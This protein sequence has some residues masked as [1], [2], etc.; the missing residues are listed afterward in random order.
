MKILI[1]EDEHDL[2][3]ALCKHLKKN[4]YG[5]DSCFNGKEALEFLSISAY[6]AIILDVQ[7]PVMNGYEFL[8]ALRSSQDTTPVL[9]LTARDS[10][11]DRVFG[12]DMGADD[13]LVK[14]FEF[15]E[16]LARIRVM[17]R[18]TYG[19]VV[20]EILIDDLMIDLSKKKVTRAAQEILLT[21]KEYEILAYLAVNQ[22]HILSRQQIQDHVWDFDYE[23]S[24]NLIDVLIKNIRKKI[25][26]KN[27]SP[28]IY[29]KR[30]LGYVIKKS[31]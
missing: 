10:L 28:L 31:D 17:T 13:Y 7:M 18:R 16:L 14:P 3:N 12:L 27:S 2:N 24:S 4:G 1:V 30:G 15:E 22:D 19:H 25:D 21:S 9:F 29:T 20:N 6:D 23:G 8:T 11:S 5:V 26:I